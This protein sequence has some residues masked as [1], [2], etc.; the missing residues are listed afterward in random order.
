[1]HSREYLDHR[2]AACLQ[3]S[4]RFDS[5]YTWGCFC[6]ARS[7]VHR[8]TSPKHRDD[9]CRTALVRSLCYLA[10]SCTELQK[11]DPWKSMKIFFTAHDNAA[12]CISY[13]ISVS[14]SVRHTPLLSVIWLTEIWHRFLLTGVT[15]L[16]QESCNIFIGRLC[17][18][19]PQRL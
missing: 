12:R 2:L 19:P 13:S 18:V 9:D 17:K 7:P 4:F 14:L 11:T 16:R 6:S 5:G 8:S 3:S 1:M 10:F 15:S